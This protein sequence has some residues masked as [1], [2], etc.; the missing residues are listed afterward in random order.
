M[1]F[2]EPHRNEVMWHVKVK[3]NTVII[4]SLVI[5]MVS[6]LNTLDC[7]DNFCLP[8]AERA[9]SMPSSP[10]QFF[11]C[12]RVFSSLFVYL[13]DSFHLTFSVT[14]GLCLPSFLCLFIYVSAS[15]FPFSLGQA[16]LHFAP[17]CER[18]LCLVI[19]SFLLQCPKPWVYCMAHGAPGSAP[20]NVLRQQDSN[21]QACCL[22][23][24]YSFPFA[25]VIEGQENRKN[26]N[27][28]SSECCSHKQ[29]K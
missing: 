22:G 5:L 14:F 17:Y 4:S 9:H 21:Y 3:N 13:Y 12:Q 1:L 23:A 7:K 27:L 10:F 19:I 29:W 8:Q 15:L 2:S 26:Q 20:V 16:V 28:R 6:K 25:E 11:N 24:R 18:G